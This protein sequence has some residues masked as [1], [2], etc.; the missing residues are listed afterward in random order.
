MSLK[1]FTINVLGVTLHFLLMQ[2][3]RTQLDKGKKKMKFF[4]EEHQKMIYNRQTW[5]A[6]CN[7]KMKKKI[8]RLS[9]FKNNEEMRILTNF[10]LQPSETNFNFPASKAVVRVIPLFSGTLHILV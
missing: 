8:L 2:L 6:E 4:N 9:K 10:G 5:H 1:N 3:K 7:Q